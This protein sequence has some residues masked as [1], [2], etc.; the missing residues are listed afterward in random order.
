MPDERTSG[1]QDIGISAACSEREMRWRRG[2][3]EMSHREDE[4]CQTTPKLGLGDFLQ[5]RLWLCGSGEGVRHTKLYTKS[6][7]LWRKGTRRIEKAQV[8]KKDL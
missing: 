8:P 7:R 5:A 3:E 2:E 6:P 1:H 4:P